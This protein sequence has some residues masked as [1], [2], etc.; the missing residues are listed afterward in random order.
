M[1]RS[2][3]EAGIVDYPT[4]KSVP[5]IEGGWATS[6]RIAEASTVLLKNKDSILPLDASKLRSI[7]I[8]GKN[9]DTGMIS[10]GGLRAGRS[11]RPPARQV[12]GAHLVPHLAAQGH[13]CEEPVHHVAVRLR[14]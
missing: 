5:D 7:A 10:G 6:R 1:L 9:S 3:F 2:E 4:R 13:L 12:A 14:R 11:P 8:I